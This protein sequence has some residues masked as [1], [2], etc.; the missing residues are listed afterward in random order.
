MDF[1]DGFV[2]DEGAVGRLEIAQHDPA[3]LKDDFAMNGRNSGVIDGKIVIGMS[4]HAVGAK[5]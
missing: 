5:F 3:I 4:A 2:V 1:A